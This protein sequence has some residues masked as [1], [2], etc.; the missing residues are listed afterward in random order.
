VD[1][2]HNT[3]TTR[4]GS[5]LSS[6][7][8]ISEAAETGL[9]SDE[10]AQRVASGH[11]NASDRAD[12]RSLI[13]ILRANVFTR[14]NAILGSLLVVVVFVGP[15]QDGLFG[16]VLA[17]NTVIGVAQE[18]RAKRTLDHLAVLTAPT[19]HAV[20]DGRPVE[21]EADAVVLDD[22][23]ELQPGDQ[24]VVD[25]LVLSSEGLEIDES[26]LSGEAV[27]V[28][29][30]HDDEVRSGSF[31][32][33]GTGRIRAIRVG[34]EAFAQKVQGDARQFSL[35]RSEL[36]QGTNQILRM[37]TWVMI[38]AGV[39]LVTSQVLR[40]GQ[41]LDDALRASVAGV[42]AM[43]PE[44]LV[45]LTTLAF[46]LGAIRMAR[47][48]VLVQELAALEG[49]ARVDVLCID[50]TGTLTEPGMSVRTIE[51]LGNTA[52]EEALG[53]LVG[54]DPSPNATIRALGALPV[55][56]DWLPEAR[57]PFSSARKWSAVQFEGRGAWVIGAP[58]VVAADGRVPVH[59]STRIDTFAARGDRVLLVARSSA[60]LDGEALPDGLEPVALVVL[61]ERIRPEARATIGYL[62]SQ[63]V[64][65]KVLSGDDPRTVASVAKR[66]GIPGSTDPVDAR[67]LPEDPVPLAQVIEASSIFGR[68]Q[69][70]Q[71]E[72]VVSA[73]Q[74]SG[75]V[76]A[77][78]GDD[79][80]NVPALKQA[81][82]SLAMGS[83]SQATRAVGRIVLLDSSFAAVPGILGEGRR[84]I[85][86]IER[87]ANLFVTKTV[88][89]AILAV[90]VGI[91]AIPFPF[92]PRHLT[93]VS[94]LTIGVPGFFLALASGSPRAH[95]GFVRRV[96]TFTVPA[97]MVAAA[98]T[99]VTYL[100][101]RGPAHATTAQARTAATLALVAIG[102]AVLVLVA[103]PLNAARAVLVGCMAGSAVLIWVAP[104]TRRIFTLEWPPT[105]ALWATAAIVLVAVPVLLMLV[106][107]GSY[108]E[109]RLPVPTSEASGPR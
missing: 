55:P 76:V 58:D 71:K 86:N 23:L 91:S 66:V 84:V 20:R 26:L 30:R 107:T 93:I 102:L 81:D 36:Q 46:A 5:G 16:V 90:V 64:Q 103:R 42:G 96:L 19:A 27:P 4:I 97:G 41:S 10:V 32:V 68:V 87:V 89:A 22:V 50:K 47:Q 104:L 25:G 29:K 85:A 9:T 3:S 6:A 98:V 39:L 34:D 57:I 28:V 95:P 15:P 54:S 65:I 77:M 8:T 44:G 2:G 33:S 75:H 52:P 51:R 109:E 78:T 38:P 92:Y 67:E 31:V 1:P 83:G 74:N 100:M 17:V 70:H 7:M 105:A 69:P 37:V 82:L 18:V 48:R 56:A 63:G 101:A 24:I 59:I 94:T 106:R 108:L 11:V 72:A 60:P 43:V 53:A 21:L 88:Y 12:S 40:S 79:V 13:Q 99:L 80:N 35:V 73:L 62:L 61:E 45:L 49:L 14:F